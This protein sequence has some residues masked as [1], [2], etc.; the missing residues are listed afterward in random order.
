MATQMSAPAIPSWDPLELLGAQSSELVTAT[1]KREIRNILKSYVGFYDPFCEMIQN[2]MDAVDE[3][4]RVET[5]RKYEK[6]LWIRVDLQGNSISVT[7][8]GIGLTE[9]QFKTFLCPNISFKSGPH[10]RGKKGV[11]STYLGYGFNRLQIGTK[12]PE[13]SAVCEL[14]DGRKWIEDD[15]GV[16][17]KPQVRQAAL[18][19]RAFE[20][21]DRG[22]TIT[23]FLGGD[24]TRP[25]D[26]S[27]VGAISAEQW[28]T[29]LLL[30][31]PLGQ[32]DLGRTAK[33]IIFDLE[34]VAPTGHVTAVVRHLARYIYPHDAIAGSIKLRDIMDEQQRRIERK[35]DVSRLPD[36]F[37]QLN[38]MWD[39]WSPAEIV[40]AMKLD[41]SE[42]ELVTKYSLNAYGYFCYSTQV[43]DQFNDSKAKLRKNMRILRGGIQMATDRMLQGDL[44][45]I[46]LTSTI[47]YQ[48]QTHVVVHLENADPDLGR[49]GFQPE[50]RQV[51]ETVAAGIVG[52]FKRFRHHLKKD[53]GS[54][55]SIFAESEVRKWVKDQEKYEREHPLVFVHEEFFLPTK[56][57]S[58]SAEPRS[59][60][61]TIALFNQLIAGGVIRGIQ[62]VSTSSHDKYDGVLRFRITDPTELH[63]YDAR[64]NPLGIQ[65][66][67]QAGVCEPCVLEYKHSLDALIAEFENGEKTES[68]IQLAVCW[69]TGTQWP[70]RYAVTS[71]LDTDNLQHR[72]FHGLTHIF[73]SDNTGERRFYAVVLSELLQYLQDPVKSQMAQREKYGS[74]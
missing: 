7:D 29:I 11:G 68:D 32:I 27:W 21:I 25:R 34:V 13:F 50:L 23:L 2:A 64:S 69:E 72:H 65:E 37:Y 41:D 15:A 45:T 26:L 30:K 40:A 16:E 8:N 36:K 61:D 10:T 60:Q 35:Q 14:H 54:V 44:L 51:A 57:L 31:T 28:V 56:A 43:F 48:N 17:K 39:K 22:S 20:L 66:I 3:R 18:H 47:G 71:L 5:G 19:H 38:A 58:I 63:L 55:P 33:E 9:V 67:T 70:K 49:K 62:L 74:A 4:E 1:R 12:R 42:K 46:P 6:R 53:T 59:E 52:Q 73:L 24:N